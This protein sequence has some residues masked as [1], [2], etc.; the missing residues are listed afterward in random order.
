MNTGEWIVPYAKFAHFKTKVLDAVKDDLDRMARENHTD[1]TF[2]YEAVYLNGRKR[3]DPD[4]IEFTIM[5]TD[6]G[7]GYSLLTKK[8]TPATGE[9]KDL[10]KRVELRK[11]EMEKR[12]K[13]CKI[14]MLNK[15]TRDESREIIK[16]LTFIS[17]NESNKTLTL[18][19]IKYEYYQW[20]E[21][22]RILR[23]LIKPLLIK[24]F[25]N[26]IK[27]IYEVAKLQNKR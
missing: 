4:Y 21:Q 14:D 5:S 8:E 13:L 15:C 24:H 23:E 25:G 26:G 20:L 18:Y 22:P 3:G 17:W 9:A 7:I 2:T 27:L 16:S 19:V 6:L 1:I 10:A 12:W 11:Q